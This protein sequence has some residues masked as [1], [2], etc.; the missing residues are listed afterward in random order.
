MLHAFALPILEAA[1]DLSSMPRD[2]VK[3]IARAAAGAMPRGS[4]VTASFG[5]DAQLDLPAVH[6]ERAP[7][8]YVR[9]VLEWQRATSV[10]FRRRLLSL[11]PRV[12]RYLGAEHGDPVGEDG[13]GDGD[14]PPAEV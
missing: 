11:P 5:V 7:E 4:V 6:F 9:G 14:R 1:Y 13:G 3:H 2:A 10:A 8:G 12:L